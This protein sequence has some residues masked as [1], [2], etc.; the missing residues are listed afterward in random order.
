MP[1]KNRMSVSFGDEDWLR[2]E[3]LAIHYQTGKSE[4]V[5]IIVSEYL[6]DKPNR[7]RLKTAK[8]EIRQTP[9]EVVAVKS[10][11]SVK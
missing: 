5:R 8:G 7:F 11:K 6:R 9:L 1:A 3:R 10:R 2:L 4:L